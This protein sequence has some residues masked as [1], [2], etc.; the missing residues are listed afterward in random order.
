MHDELDTIKT[1]QAPFEDL[2]YHTHN[3]RNNPCPMHAGSDHLSIWTDADG[4]IRYKCHNPAGI[5]DED[6]TGTIIDLWMVERGLSVEDAIGELKAKYGSGESTGYSTHVPQ[7]RPEPVEVIRPQTTEKTLPPV[8]WI[9]YNGRQVQGMMRKRDK[10]GWEALFFDQATSIDTVACEY[11]GKL[12]GFATARWDLPDGK[13]VRPM[14]FDGTEWQTGMG[15]TRNHRRPLYKL[16]ELAA[17]GQQTVYI[18]E[19]EKCM[20]ALQKALNKC[21]GDAFFAG[22]DESK[23]EAIVTTYLQGG[24]G[25]TDLYCLHDKQVIIVPDM[26]EPGAKKAHQL[27]LNMPHNDIRVLWPESNPNIDLLPE[28][29]GKDIADFLEEASFN[30]KKFLG[31][32][33]VHPRDIF[34]F[35][36]ETSLA[37]TRQWYDDSKVRNYY[38]VSRTTEEGKTKTSKHKVQMREIIDT[39]HNLVDEWPRMIGPYLAAQGPHWGDVAAPDKAINFIEN[40]TDLSSWLQLTTNVVWSDSQVWLDGE[41]TRAANFGELL[42]ALKDQSKHNYTSYKTIP[43]HPP[44][45]NTI[46][47]ADVEPGDGRYLEEFISK[48]NPETELDRQL[49]ES[50]VLTPFWGGPPGQR[51]AFV[52]T[53]DHGRGV[54]KSTTIEAIAKIYDGSI[55]VQEDEEWNQVTQ[56]LLTPGSMKKRVLF[57]DNMKKMLDRGGLEAAITRDEISGKRMYEGDATIPNY[58]TWFM[59]ANTPELSTD[60]ASRSVVIKIGPK[61]HDFD[62]KKWFSVF[63]VRHHEQ[64]I[65]DIKARFLEEPKSSIDKNSR[66]PA[67]DEDIMTKFENADEL[68]S[69]I[70]SRK[71]DVDEE[72][73]D[74]HRTYDA[75]CELISARGLDPETDKVHIP[76]DTLKQTV[77][78]LWATK[79]KDLRSGKAFWNHW[80][81]ISVQPFVKI[82]WKKG[83][84]RDD[85]GLWWNVDQPGE[86]VSLTNLDYAGDVVF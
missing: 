6:A 34:E 19:G 15:I 41:K 29:N 16:S 64:I 44:L 82:K 55:Q 50:A 39:I 86:K 3:S 2:G 31:R 77:G 61:K 78:D 17:A 9:E 11:N 32:P 22:E 71:G 8:E 43:H 1:L 30:V 58:F 27:A 70:A 42:S 65:A 49:L 84:F 14:H 54:G 79:G 28:N 35:E 83:K 5:P 52:L 26:D 75:I 38:T 66:F 20:H 80:K 63:L 4:V 81:K 37:V 7:K 74:A 57:I 12:H 10:G 62:F 60:L 25:V 13:F 33:G 23:Y 46:Y 56:R 85:R 45:P 40:S 68:M 18:V 69:L 47:T 73:K 67:W 24:A 36:P 59:S 72:A 51:P 48:L 53:T 76:I 21:K